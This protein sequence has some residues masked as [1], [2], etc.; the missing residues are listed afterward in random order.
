M[1]LDIA[2]ADEDTIRAVMEVLQKQWR[3]PASRRCG[4]RRVS[5]A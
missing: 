5:P 2:A 3:P 1:V 4:V